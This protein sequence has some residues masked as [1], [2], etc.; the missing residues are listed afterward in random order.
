VTIAA[1]KGITIIAETPDLSVSA[2][3]S[4]LSAIVDNLVS[5]PT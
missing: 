3:P 4:L 5:N 2:E 1:E